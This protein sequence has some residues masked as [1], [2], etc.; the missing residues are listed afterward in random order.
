MSN[1]VGYWIAASLVLALAL[2]QS[3]FAQGVIVPPVPSDIRVPAGNIPFLKGEAVGTQ[4]YICL[5]TTTGFS[6]TFVAPQATLF[7]MLKFLQFELHQQI[8]THFLS[9]NPDENGTPRPTWQ[10]SLDTSAVWG[11]AAAS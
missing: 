2:E 10:S 5:P 7:V 1:R 4:N 3:S 9:P 6:W 11:R 8:T